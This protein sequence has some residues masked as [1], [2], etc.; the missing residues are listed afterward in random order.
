MEERI[1]SIIPDNSFAIRQ[2]S[3]VVWFTGLSGSGK[4]TIS[5]LLRNE[6]VKKG[7]LVQELDGDV[8]R[9][10]L[11]CD[12]GFNMNSRVE[13]IRRA[14]EVAEIL[15]NSGLICLCSFITPTR[16]IRQKVRK[17]IGENDLIEVYVNAPIEVCEL[18]DVKGLY[19]KARA[20]I[21]PDFTGI[22]SSFEPPENPDL[23]IRTD[24]LTIEDSV[25]RCL[26]FVIN[27]VKA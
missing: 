26:T 20:G 21:I 9:K 7:F 24:L 16:E 3:K 11:N 10:G 8:L 18:R 14:A 22:S 25:E 13:N 4:T 1:K 17:I 12:L 15:K 27:L 2:I 23:E 6:L 5:N 19:K